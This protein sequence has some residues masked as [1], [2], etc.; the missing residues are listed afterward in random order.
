MNRSNF[1]LSC[2]VLL[3]VL[4]GVIGGAVTGGVAGYYAAQSAAPAPV[5]VTSAPSPVAASS[6]SAPPVVGATTN[7]TLKEESAV[8]DS[9]RKAKP[10]VVTIINELNSQSR[11]GVT[12]TASGSGVIID[13]QG[14]I[15]TNNHVV[16]GEKNLTVIYADGSKADATILGA[17]ATIDIAVLKVEGKVPAYA[18]FGDSNALE[19]GQI[20]I[21]IGSPLGDYRGTVT[22]GVVS[23]LNRR[24]GRQNGLIQTDAAINN[25]NSGGP[26]INSLGQVIGINTLVVRNTNE[27]N[28]AEG[29][30]FAIPSNQVKEIVNQLLTKGR[31]D[32]PFIGITYQEL[33]PQTAAAMNLPATTQGV[34][35]M[36]VEAGS[37]AAQAGL[38][39]RDVV[40]AINSQKITP[41]NPLASLLLGFK[42][43]DPVT[44]TVLRDGKQ[45]SVKV[46]L[47]TRPA[48]AGQ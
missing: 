6:Q 11:R 33:D 31:V 35:V 27:G 10:A 36:Q 2:L 38:K 18:Q 29:L 39:E 7:M 25:G 23:G 19:P 42:I 37:P 5:V 22:V 12:P 30:G 17:D 8:I 40:Q 20:A 24:V 41:E 34:V 47:G 44:L 9:V 28:V 13:P 1:W 48:P 21:A 15:I 32:R 3:V 26:L 16:A 14:Y 4:L 45:I 43:G 46:T